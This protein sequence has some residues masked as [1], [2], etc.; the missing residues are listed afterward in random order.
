MP[1]LPEVETTVRAI[2]KFKSKTLKKVVIHNRN[3]RWKVDNEVVSKTQNKKI[4]EI[5][6]RAKYILIHFNLSTLVIH[7]GMSGKLRIQN[8][9][10]NYFKKH[11]HAEFIF[12]N[13][14]IIFNDTRR[15]G[16]I[17]LMDKYEEHKLIKY[18]GVEPLSQAFNQKFLFDLCKSS[19]L[20]IK[21]LLME[22]TKVVGIGNIY[23]SESLFLA[24]VR[25]T[26]IS[27]KITNAEADKIV[28]SVKEVLKNAIRVGGTTLND[29]Y[30]ADG[31]PGYFNLKLN[32]YG[33]ENQECNL[34]K[35][36]I[37]KV[38]LGQRA[39]F[40]CSKCQN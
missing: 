12:E 23:A 27:K 26:K 10:D 3:L 5:N 40:F 24:K 2:N 16:S 14:K 7:L 35:N 34:C 32:V 19:N 31:N 1:E 15:F 39:T 6:R 9:S 28:K 21:K 37:Q 11:D 30:S 22:Q 17:H 33:R 29:F 36:L 4:K 13:E 38:V 18:L 8:V 20:Q 25:P